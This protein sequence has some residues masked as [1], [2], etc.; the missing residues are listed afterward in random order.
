MYGRISLF[1]LLITCGARGWADE[2]KQPRSGE[3]WA[4]LI[5]VNDY[6]YFN[7]LFYCGKD[8]E[9]L[10][11][12]LNI[13]GFA[14]DHIYLMTDDAKDSKYRTTKTNI[15]QQIDGIT[16]MAGENDVLLL[17]FSGHGISLNGQS[18]VCPIDA[19][20]DAANDTLISVDSIY[21]RFDAKNCRA[22]LKILLVDACRNDPTP[23]VKA[24]GDAAADAKK[25]I[26]TL[27]KVPS[28]M[29]LFNSCSL[30][31]FSREDKEFQHG[32]FSHFLVEGLSGNA[33]ANKDGIVT[34]QEL[35]DYTTRFTQK[36]VHD[37]TGYSQQPKLTL[38]SINAVGAMNFEIGRVKKKEGEG[39]KPGDL[40][41]DNQLGLEL[42]WC[43]AGTFTMGSPKSEKERGEDEYPV[44]VELTKGFWLGQTGVTQ[45]QWHAL[46]KDQL[47]PWKGNARV[48][49]GDQFPATCVDWSLAAEFCRRMTVAEAKAGRL[50]KGWKFDL[51]SEAQREYAC[52]AGSNGAFSFGEASRNLD[53]FGW[54]DTNAASAGQE[55]AHEVRQKTPNA[56]GLYDLHGNVN[57]WCA[58]F[59][60]ST[61]P[62][63][64]NPRVAVS[65]GGDEIRVNRGGDFT[66]SSDKCRSAARNANA[67]AYQSPTVGFRI[68]LHRQTD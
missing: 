19:K 54:F 46:M 56:W 68:V 58:D 17:G 32:V 67:P 50:P 1:L 66:S 45:S 15:N 28:G 36:R 35:A 48:K 20:L 65:P 47:E 40:R 55:F 30:G 39:D 12:Q 29:V 37:G 26:Q 16:R 49:V 60:Q 43:P 42:V 51:P 6:A 31:E 24:A 59:Y 61:L 52:R 18:Y 3:K 23:E 5:G 9:D 34:L 57:E 62:G 21:K 33:D 41:H 63:G 53:K 38:N 10:A 22:A 13:A 64:K 14:E 7:K 44:T 4:L 27:E 11:R 8:Q 2:P 25:L